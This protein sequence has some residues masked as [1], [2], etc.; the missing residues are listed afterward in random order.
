MDLLT[1][2]ALKLD[3]IVSALDSRLRP[4]A[5]VLFWAGGEAF[6]APPGWRITREVPLAGSARRRIV[7]LTRA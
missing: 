2:R 1:A 4:E 7:E 5:S 6:S 3:A